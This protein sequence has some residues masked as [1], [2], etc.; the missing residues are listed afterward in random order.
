MYSTLW[1]VQQL[2]RTTTAI[3][4]AAAN[5]SNNEQQQMMVNILSRFNQ[6]ETFWSS[7]SIAIRQHT[8]SEELDER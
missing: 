1:N 7:M 6:V 4:T 5:N 3:T 2:Q 8:F